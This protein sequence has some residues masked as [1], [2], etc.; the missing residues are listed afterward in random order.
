MLGTPGSR[1]QQHRET[2]LEPN[3]KKLVDDVEKFGCHIIHVRSDDHL[4]GWS[5]TVGLY[6]MLGQAEVIVVGL[7]TDT[8]Q[9]LLNQT[10][11]RM[12]SGLRIEEG[13][14]QRELLADVECEFRK[15]EHRLLRRVVGYA[16]WFYGGDEFP[17]YQCIYPDLENRFPWQD[18]F[19]AS[20][21]NRQALLF[22][23]APQ[24]RLEGDFW[25]D[26]DPQ[27]SLYDWQFT[28]GPHA[29]VFTTKR[30]MNDE[31][32]IVYVC[33]DAND[34]SWQFHEPSDSPPE[35][36]EYVCFHHILDKDPAVKELHDLPSGW[37]AWRE[38]VAGVWTREPQPPE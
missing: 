35:S 36:A 2:Q 14:R 9:S 16:S 11:K 26:H 5:Y 33:H 28:V 4:P 15:V 20:W 13:L 6:E 22:R 10:A 19:D 1:I 32:P 37:H 3:E 17:V 25:A 29:G 24:T 38:G 21:R 12:K 23:D 31:E 34:G 8:A 7:K 27:S 30:I 18:G